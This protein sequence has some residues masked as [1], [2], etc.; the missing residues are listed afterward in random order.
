V[1]ALGIDEECRVA[2]LELHQRKA[3]TETTRPRTIERTM[4]QMMI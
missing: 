4:T 1:T 3:M 2:R